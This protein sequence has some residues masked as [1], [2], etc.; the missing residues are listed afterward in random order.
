MQWFGVWELTIL[1]LLKHMFQIIQGTNNQLCW[2]IKRGTFTLTGLEMLEILD[3]YYVVAKLF[4][5]FFHFSLI[6]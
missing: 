2:L 3:I 6:Y 4:Y 1:H 5:P